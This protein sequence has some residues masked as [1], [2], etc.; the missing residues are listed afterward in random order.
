MGSLPREMAGVGSAISRGSDPMTDSEAGL[1]TSDRP[2][3]ISIMLATTYGPRIVDLLSPLELPGAA[4]SSAEESVG[5]AF[6]VAEQVGEPSLAG[7]IRAAASTSFLDGFQAACITVG[8]IAL[9]GSLMASRFL[10]ARATK[11]SDNVPTSV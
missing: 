6:A 11:P 1:V 5:A 8:I 7:I 9:I 2:L 3:A 10:P 4:V